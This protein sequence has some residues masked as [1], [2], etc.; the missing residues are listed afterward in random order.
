MSNEMVV[1]KLGFIKE[2]EYLLY[3][4][5]CCDR[6]VLPIPNSFEEILAGLD[7]FGYDHDKEGFEKYIEENKL[8]ELFDKV[9]T[10]SLLD[11]FIEIYIYNTKQF[12]LTLSMKDMIIKQIAEAEKL[13]DINKV[14][15]LNKQLMA[16]ENLKENYYQSMFY[17]LDQVKFRL[18]REDEIKFN[19][20]ITST[21]KITY[22][23]NEEPRKI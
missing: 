15:E 22:K 3:K 14:Q 5:V 17:I 1:K 10:M 21:I 7:N 13:G 11:R 16:I 4:D 23:S 12:S 19:D 2:E 18:S 20:I 6:L 8:L 9:K